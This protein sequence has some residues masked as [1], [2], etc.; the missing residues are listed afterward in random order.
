MLIMFYKLFI[1]LKNYKRGKIYF[2]KNKVLIEKNNW[3][4]N[5]GKVDIN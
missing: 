4:Y 2:L 3:V 1:N 5:Y